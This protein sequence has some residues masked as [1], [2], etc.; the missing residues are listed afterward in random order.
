MFQ[1]RDKLLIQDLIL[2]AGNYVIVKH[3]NGLYTNYFH[4]SETNVTVGQTIQIGEVSGF[5]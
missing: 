3:P 1:V 5:M 4:M 2:P